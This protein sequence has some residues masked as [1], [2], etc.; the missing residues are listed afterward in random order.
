M[1]GWNF[2]NVDIVGFWL[3]ARVMPPVDRYI[4]SQSTVE[5][6]GRPMIPWWRY[7]MKE[8]SK[9]S[10]ERIVVRPIDDSG[11]IRDAQKKSNGWNS[12]L[13]NVGRL[14]LVEMIG[15]PK[16]NNTA[17]DFFFFG[18]WMTYT[19]W[20]ERCGAMISIS[21]LLTVR[22]ST[23]HKRQRVCTKD[24]HLGSRFFLLCQTGRSSVASASLATNWTV[25][26]FGQCLNAFE[27]VKMLFVWLIKLVQI[28]TY[29]NIILPRMICCGRI[30][31]WRGFRGCT[32]SCIC[33]SCKRYRTGHSP[34]C[35]RPNS[36]TAMALHHGWN[37]KHTRD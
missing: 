28:F 7:G 27:L 26:H 19:L 30:C 21:S 10:G 12:R 13:Q 9:R 15:P 16:T 32:Y 1:D 5:S 17:R 37:H 33:G 36:Q 4:G 14:S 6:M 8:F 29:Q 11:M 2:C 22:K 18:N 3:M 34:E 35:W 25:L 31:C 20:P 23:D 24:K